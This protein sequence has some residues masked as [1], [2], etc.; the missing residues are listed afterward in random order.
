MVHNPEGNPE[1]RSFQ[2]GASEVPFGTHVDVQATNLI[3]QEMFLDDA[4]HRISSSPATI[5][6]KLPTN[7]QPNSLQ[8]KVK[9]L[10]QKAKKNMW[11]IN[12]KKEVTQKFREYDQ[13]LEALTF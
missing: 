2:S 12:F 4:A 13:K 10:M 1:V 5:I 6:H 7:S 3:L 9:K 8:A 11:K